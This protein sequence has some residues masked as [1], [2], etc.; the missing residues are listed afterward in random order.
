TLLLGRG[1]Y[2]AFV[3]SPGVSPP[4]PIALSKSQTAVIP[5][6]TPVDL[7]IIV[8]SGVL[9]LAA[10]FSLGRGEPTVLLF[11]QRTPR[12]LARRTAWQQLP[13]VGGDPAGGCQPGSFLERGLDHHRRRQ[14]LRERERC[15]GSRRPG[16][17]CRRHRRRQ[18]LSDAGQPRLAERVDRPQHERL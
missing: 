16:P 3:Q 8:L 4:A 9:V 12:G 10:V 6:I 18:V 7:V 14:Q 17:L 5:V 2:L 1:N 15:V 13:R 11:L